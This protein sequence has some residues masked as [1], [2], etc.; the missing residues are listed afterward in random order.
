MGT[1]GIV[2]QLEINAP[3]QYCNY[4]FNSHCMLDGIDLVAGPSGVFSLGGDNDNGTE[5]SAKFRTLLSDF[6]SSILKRVRRLLLGME[7]TG[8]MTVT[9]ENDQENPRS[10]TIDNS[11]YDR[12]G[13]CDVFIGRNGLGRYWSF[14]FENV[15]GCDFRID[16]IEASIYLVNRR[17]R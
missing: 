9:L 14:E 13:S 2:L 10:Y 16:K 8:D 6:G 7:A 5:I 11:N 15:D 3:R 17:P 1:T 12:T 4:D